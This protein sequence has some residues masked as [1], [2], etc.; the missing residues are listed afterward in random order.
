MLRA[1]KHEI[2]SMHGKICKRNNRNIRG[3]VRETYGK[4]DRSMEK[5]VVDAQTR[6]NIQS[7][8][9]TGKH[10]TGCKRGKARNRCKVRENMQTVP[11]IG[12]LTRY[13]YQARENT[14]NTSNNWLLFRFCLIERQTSNH[15]SKNMVVRIVVFEITSTCRSF[16]KTL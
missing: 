12:K 4:F 11:S 8:P 14:C 13:R 2:V 5:H 1:G 6:E 3:K 16:D 10:T 15:F 7:L 9:S